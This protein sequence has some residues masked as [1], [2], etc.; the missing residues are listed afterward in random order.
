MKQLKAVAEGL[1]AVETLDN[2][3]FEQLYDGEK[4]P[5]ELADDLKAAM[6]E[7]REKDKREAAESVK[8]RRLEAARAAALEKQ[9]LEDAAKALEEQGK[10]AKFKPTIMTYNDL[11]NTAKPLEKNDDEDIKKAPDEEASVKEI[12]DDEIYD[13]HYDDDM[14]SEEELAVY[15]TDYLN[16]DEDDEV[17][18][19]E[20]DNDPDESKE[21]RN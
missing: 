17:E 14:P 21:K 10:N 2:K 5:E 4:T 18:K 15:D 8:Q 1:L 9:K 11:T 20:E 19:G 3:Q 16:D 7:R 6:E 12:L 13:D